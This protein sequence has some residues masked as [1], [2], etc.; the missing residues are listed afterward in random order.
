MPFLAPLLPALG[1]AAVGVGVSAIGNKLLGGS[2][3]AEGNLNKPAIRAVTSPGLRTT[4]KGGVVS[5]RRPRVQNLLQRSRERANQAA[6]AFS[7]QL[8]G[9]SDRFQ[10]NV[11]ASQELVGAGRD[12]FGRSL[13][14][15]LGER[16]ESIGTLRQNLSR[17]G[18]LGSSFGEQ[19]ISDRLRSFAETERDLTASE[20]VFAAEEGQKLQK[21]LTSNL[22][23][24]TALKS[25]IIQARADVHNAAIDR[26]LSQGNF[27]TDVSVRLATNANNAV[28]Q[29]SAILAQIEQERSRGVGAFLDPII[30]QITGSIFP[31]TA[32]A[33]A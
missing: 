25:Q 20:A 17:R 19:A 24:E 27:E 31:G 13:E 22:L 10:Q 18:I 23:Q 12:A 7:T 30:S 28:T 11:D 6:G 2:S 32:G 14:R 26:E 3:G 33:T 21:T 29:G 9:L 8:G 1:S 5:K 16:R 4:L 15:L